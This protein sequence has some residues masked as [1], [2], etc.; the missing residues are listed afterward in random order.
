M[1][2]GSSRSSRSARDEARVSLGIA[3]AAPPAFGG[4][5]RQHAS[6]PDAGPRSSPVRRA[7]EDPSGAP[8]E[9]GNR[10]P[11][12]LVHAAIP[13]EGASR[14]LAPPLRAALRGSR[15]QPLLSVR[16]AQ[17]RNPAQLPPRPAEC[18]AHRGSRADSARDRQ[19]AQHARRLRRAIPQIECREPR[20]LEQH[21]RAVVPGAALRGRAARP[22]PGPPSLRVARAA[23]PQ[24]Q[25]AGGAA[26]AAIRSGHARGHRAAGREL[27]PAAGRQPDRDPHRALG[28]G[29]AGPAPDRRLAGLGQDVLKLTARRN[30]SL[31]VPL[32]AMPDAHFFDFGHRM[33]LRLRLS[34]DLVVGDARLLVQMN[35]VTLADD[36][37]NNTF[38][39]AIGTVSVTIPPHA[40]KSRNLL[41][42]TW[43][44][45]AHGA[46][47]G[48]VA[49]LLS[50]SEL[51]LPR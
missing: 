9:R 38:R 22:E 24:R 30:Y 3:L 2:N 16:H 35:E 33:V 50:T 40:L 12:R 15:R 29:R 32:N 36:T 43:I 8:A 10:R 31:T 48:V 42:I 18:D 51:Y 28:P 20:D 1:R 45:P 13:M 4:G 23:Y 7:P 49:W 46:S 11:L 6:D 26:A 5:R 25:P 47:Q 41:R 34:P 21:Q 37:V 17:L 14:Q 39:R 27:L 19:A 44:G